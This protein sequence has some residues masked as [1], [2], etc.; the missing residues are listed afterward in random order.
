M[1]TLIVLFVVAGF[2]TIISLKYY[3]LIFS[4]VG[5]ICWIGLWAYVKDNPPTGVLQGSFV[6]EI[7]MYAFI[8]IGVTVMLLYFRTRIKNIPNARNGI[9]SEVIQPEGKPALERRGLM[10]ISTEEYRARVRKSLNRK[11]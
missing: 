6:H 9:D 1:T 11:K 5:M 8:I 4:F 3:N 2:F 7:M 10:D